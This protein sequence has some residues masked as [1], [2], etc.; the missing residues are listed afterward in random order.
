MQHD[1]LREGIPHV[2]QC[3][4]KKPSLI[5]VVYKAQERLL[6]AFGLDDMVCYTITEKT[7]GMALQIGMDPDK[8]IWIKTANLGPFYTATDLEIL[9]SFQLIPQKKAQFE[10][11]ASFLRE[12]RNCDEL[13]SYLAHGGRTSGW[14][15]AW[16]KGE[17]L[18]R[19]FGKVEDN[20]INF[21]ATKYDLRHFGKRGLFVVHTQLCPSRPADPSTWSTHT[22]RFDHDFCGSTWVQ[23]HDLRKRVLACPPVFSRDDEFWPIITDVAQKFEQRLMA[24]LNFPNRWGPE[25]EGLVFH[26]PMRL[27]VIDPNWAL[28]K[29]ERTKFK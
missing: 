2:Y 17:L 11:Y 24:N 5:S 14:D 7:D 16:I 28:R 3:D 8:G 19:D 10:G 15:R 23:V 4:P 13:I 12:L 20:T 18:W 9:A 21:V 22:I 27:K 26:G 25:R 1:R 29:A 6:Q